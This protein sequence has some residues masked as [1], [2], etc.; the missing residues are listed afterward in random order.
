[1]IPA[2]KTV[3]LVGP[4]G[5]GKSTVVQLLQRFYDPA[6]GSIMVDGL[7]IRQLSLKWYRDQVRC[8]FFAELLFA[9]RKLPP[10]T[11]TDD[12]LRSVNIT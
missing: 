10:S 9:Q 5:C 3:A 6:S 11:A 8:C 4:S 2:G 1:M 7:D 12:A